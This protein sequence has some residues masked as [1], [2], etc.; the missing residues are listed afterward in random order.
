[1]RVP[2]AIPPQGFDLGLRDHEGNCDLCFLK[3]RTKLLAIEREEPGRAL[4]WAA[5]ERAAQER[6]EVIET[7]ARFRLGDS[8]E[9]I[10]R[11]ASRQ[12]AFP[13]LDEEDEH[14]AECGLWCAGE[15]QTP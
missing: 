4:W 6:A 1:M 11:D 9:L 12:R 3:S 7:G 8:Y 2:A 14:D 5:Q 13:F 15:G 10:A